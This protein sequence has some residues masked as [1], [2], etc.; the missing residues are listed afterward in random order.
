MN[1]INKFAIAYLKW[2]SPIVLIA[3]ILSG[4]GKSGDTLFYSTIGWVTII[5]V[6]LLIY[7]TFALAFQDQLRNRFVRWIAGIKENDERES[8]IAGNSSKKTFIFMTGFIILLIFLS[9]IRIEIYKNKIPDPNGKRNGRISFS[10][11]LQFIRPQSDDKPATSS[12]DDRNYFVNYRFPLAVDG[13][14]LLVGLM[15]IGSFYYFSR[16]EDPV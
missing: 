3:A 8:L 16:K 15:Q 13:T 7:I 4:M 12:D 9:I 2:A 10:M 6:L 14:L 1:K 5:W 11:S